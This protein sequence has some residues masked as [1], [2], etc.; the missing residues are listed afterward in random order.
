MQYRIN[1]SKVISQAESINDQAEQLAAKISSLEQLEQEC[2]SCWKGDAADAF[3]AKLSQLRSE[4]TGTKNQ[5][6]N[7]ASTIR[8]CAERIRR[9]D[10]EAERRAAALSSGQ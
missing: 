10:Q 5:M 6:K 8:E 4:M 3:T 2:R 9:E 1:Y 7:L